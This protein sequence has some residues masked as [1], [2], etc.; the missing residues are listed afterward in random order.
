[1]SCPS[2]PGRDLPGLQPPD[3]KKGGTADALAR[4]SLEMTLVSAMMIREILIQDLGREEFRKIE[5]WANARAA[6]ITR[7]ELGEGAG[8]A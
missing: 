6:E 1:M 7:E 2:C 3:L 4:L 8:P 5:D